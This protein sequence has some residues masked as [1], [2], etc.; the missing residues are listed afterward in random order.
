MP[1]DEELSFN[2]G[3]EIDWRVFTGGYEE[4]Y[5]NLLL[6]R[7]QKDGGLISAESLKKACASHLHRGLSYLAGKG[8]EYLEDAIGQLVG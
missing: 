7:I 4:L 8:D 6:C 3:V 1:P 5:L 2:G